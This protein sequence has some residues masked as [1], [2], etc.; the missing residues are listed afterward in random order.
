MSQLYGK[1]KVESIDLTG[2]DNEQPETLQARKHAKR[3]MPTPP[4]SSQSVLSQPSRRERDDWVE[5]AGPNDADAEIALT[6]DFDDNVY[7]SYQLYGILNT[8]VVGCQ[9]YRGQ[10]T[11][12]EYVVVRREPQN[13]VPTWNAMV[14]AHTDLQRDRKSVV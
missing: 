4:T 10:A 13:Q 11:V 8:K 12:G 9:Y 14:E 1:R 6:Q 5:D 2:S 7:E 3:S